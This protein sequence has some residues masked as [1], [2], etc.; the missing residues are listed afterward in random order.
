MASYSEENLINKVTNNLNCLQ[1]ILEFNVKHQLLFFRISSD[2]V[3]FA[4]HPICKFNWQKYFRNE[5][6]SIGKYIKKHKIR[7]S[8][9]PDQFVLINAIKKDVLRK[10]ID[11]LI[12]HCTVLDLMELDSAAKIQIHVGGVYGDKEQSIKRFINQYAQ[13]PSMIKK[14]LVIENDHIAYSIQDCIRI[15]H[16]IGIPVVFDLLHHECYNN[17]ENVSYAIKLAAATWRKNDGCLM[18]DYSSQKAKAKIGTHAEH[19]NFQHFKRFIDNL[20]KLNTDFD[21]MFEIKDKEKSALR[22]LALLKKLPNFSKHFKE[23]SGIGK[24]D[25]NLF[26]VFRNV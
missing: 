19:I 3:P 5:F 15:N 10:S 16:E 11:E 7:I 23:N 4:A 25:F 1:K 2:L 20:I 6:C 17:Q 18:I 14:R 12:Y 26:K 24:N 13:L 21:I 9:H 22:A 8:M